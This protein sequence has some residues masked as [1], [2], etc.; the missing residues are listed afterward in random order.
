MPVLISVERQAIGCAKQQAPST[1]DI[2]G[3]QFFG[4]PSPQT[5]KTVTSPSSTDLQQSSQKASVC[6]AS[7]ASS[8]ILQRHVQ[9]RCLLLRVQCSNVVHM[10]QLKFGKC[11]CSCLHLAG[12]VAGQ[13]VHYGVGAVRNHGRLDAKVLPP[14]LPSRS[15]VESMQELVVDARA[16]VA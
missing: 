12:H 4:R 1:S 5:I 3:S 16:V 9:I 13:T 15:A 8:Q 2:I 7:P 11:A 6:P 10:A 14:T